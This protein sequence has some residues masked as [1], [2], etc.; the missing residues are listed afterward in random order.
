MG[1]LTFLQIAA[2]AK[3]GGLPGLSGLGSAIARFA[4]P[5]IPSYGNMIYMAHHPL[6]YTPTFNLRG[7]RGIGA[8]TQASGMEKALWQQGQ[9]RSNRIR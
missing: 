5:W 6:P 1:A 3:P 4:G 9:I 2:S 7:F 8:F